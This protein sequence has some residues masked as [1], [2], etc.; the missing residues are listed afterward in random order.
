MFMVS[1]KIATL[2]SVGLAW[3]LTPNI[4]GLAKYNVSLNGHTETVCS[5]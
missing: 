1:K 3:T 5:G 2:Q 4:S